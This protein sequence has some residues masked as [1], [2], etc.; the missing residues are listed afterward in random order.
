MAGPTDGNVITGGTPARPAIPAKLSF[1]DGYDID[2][3]FGWK[4][5]SGF[6]AEAE[7]GWRSAKIDRVNSNPW[8]RPVSS[9]DQ[10]DGQR[11]VRLQHRAL[12]PTVSRRGHRRADT[13]VS[14]TSPA[15]ARMRHSASTVFNECRHQQLQWQLIAGISA[16]ISPSRGAVRGLSLHP[17]QQRQHLERQQAT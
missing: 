17:P 12:H 13:I 14:T 1:K 9:R 6:R 15:P 8:T 5:S 11:A 10:R 16:P 3:A 7:L 2:G 4:W